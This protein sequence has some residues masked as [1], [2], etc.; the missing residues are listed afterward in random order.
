[1]ALYEI[2]ITTNRICTF[3]QKDKIITQI[4]IA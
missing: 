3:S 2:T 1:M 4:H